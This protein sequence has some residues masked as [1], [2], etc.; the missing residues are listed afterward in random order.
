MV[1]TAGYFKV[2]LEGEVG[3]YWS[4]RDCHWFHHTIPNFI[5]IVVMKAG[6]DRNQTQGPLHARH[7]LSPL[8]HIPSL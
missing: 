4:L 3:S 6:R 1:V 7:R 2:L 5:V 8:C